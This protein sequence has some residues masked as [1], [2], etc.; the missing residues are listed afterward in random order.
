MKRSTFTLG[1]LVILL[2]AYIA[3][4]AFR[5]APPNFKH[6]AGAIADREVV[7]VYGVE[8]LSKF[9]AVNQS[10]YADSTQLL[11]QIGARGQEQVYDFKNAPSVSIA[12][13][14][15]VVFFYPQYLS[16]GGVWN[17]YTNKK[18]R[19]T[20]KQLDLEIYNPGDSPGATVKV[21]MSN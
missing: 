18:T 15:S 12:S 2:A 8:S 19:S 20:K 7:M 10:K 6:S 5:T 4:Y 13:P 3:Y 11:Y 9:T 17:Y 16:P 14:D 21:T 1:A